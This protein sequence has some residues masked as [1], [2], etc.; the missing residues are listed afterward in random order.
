MIRRILQLFGWSYLPDEKVLEVARAC[1]E[2]RGRPWREPILLSR[3]P[4]T[5]LV[6]TNA[7]AKGGNARVLVDA[8]S[9][10]I[11]LAGF[12]DR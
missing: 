11:R 12:A 9:G 10:R 3:G 8:R 7:D 5:T 4:R 2:E 6:T 1:C